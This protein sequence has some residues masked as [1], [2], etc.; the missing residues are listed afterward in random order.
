MKHRYDKSLVHESEGFDLDDFVTYEDKRYI[1]GKAKLNGLNK[2][3]ETI[4][5]ICIE[6]KFYFVS[7]LQVYLIQNH[8]ELLD[9]FRKDYYMHKSFI[10][11]RKYEMCT[12]SWEDDLN[13]ALQTEKYYEE[14][15]ERFQADLEGKVEEL[16]LYYENKISER[17]KMIMEYEEILNRLIKTPETTKRFKRLQKEFQEWLLSGIDPPF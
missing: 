11:S 14:Q 4:Q 7:Q 10:E 15:F 8:P 3:L 16:R 5:K 13:K 17:D 2:D 12:S 1:K 9:A 6:N